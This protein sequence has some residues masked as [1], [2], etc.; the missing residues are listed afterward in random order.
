MTLLQVIKKVL[1]FFGYPAYSLLKKII[2]ITKKIKFK[3]RKKK[4]KQ[5]KVK[6][7]KNGIKK[8]PYVIGSFF[9]LLL[10]VGLIFFYAN[11]LK[12]LPNV[13]LIYDPPNQ[14]TKIYDRNGK[15]LYKFY[16]DENRTWVGLDKIPKNLVWATLAIEDKNFYK[17]YGLSI[18]GIFRA[19]VHNLRNKE[20]VS[21]R[22]GSTITQQL[23]KNVFF[24][25]SKTWIRKAKEAVLSLQLERKL[26]KDEILERYL[27]QVAYGGET[28]G[29]QEASIKYFGKNVWEISAAEAT[30]L[31]GLPA[32]PSSYSPFSGNI[33]Y[34]FLRQKHVIDEMVSA[35][36]IDKKT[37]EEIKNQ[38]IELN[39]ETKTIAAPH[40]VFYVKNMIETRFGFKNIDRLGLNII[41]S[42]DSEIQEKSEKIVSQEINQVKR[43]GIS[44]G[45]AIVADV[46][47]GDVLAMV[48]S[49]DYYAKDIDG[50]VNV[51]TSLRQPGSSIKPINYLLALQNGKTLLSTVDD[52][53]VSYEIAGQKPYKP[54]NYNG[55]FMGRVTLKT[56]L[57][58]SLNIP[59]VKLLAENGVENMISMAEKMGITTWGDRARFGLALALGS[60]EVRMTEM[61]QAYSTFANMGEKIKIDPVVRID[62]YLGEKIYEKQ[63]EKE[64]IFDPAYAFLIN[65]ILSDDLAR[66]PVFGINSKLKIQNK[67]VAVKTG[68]TNSLKDNW[69]IGWTPS[70]IVAAWVGNNDSK[71]MSWVASGVSGATPIWNKIMREMLANKEN[72]DWSKPDNVISKNIC[73]REEFFMDGTENNVDCGYKLTP[74]PTR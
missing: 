65:K 15:I 12:D 66:A 59:S 32:A 54:Q 68:T 42:L 61:V 3:K 60:G 30:F 58:S 31:A 49:K 19:V 24:D 46:K 14:S 16:K 63:I 25:R 6:I 45:A 5:R 8:A 20:N 44:N 23:I 73:G 22:G 27:N 62:N 57:A 29:A 72:E 26:S 33:D 48:G 64:K 43:L 70:Y 10:T 38:K 13:N 53:P 69:C 9:L 40:F 28:Y 39:S 34:A 4:Q 1:M 37:A 35:G 41:T 52:S 17:H 18:N 67:T 47:T 74:V 7:K 2:K 50:K 11:V 21:L 51:T 71:P 36:Y 56:A 55:R